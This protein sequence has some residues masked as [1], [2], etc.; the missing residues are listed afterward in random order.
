MSIDIV[1]F[2]MQ[3]T[4]ACAEFVISEAKVCVHSAPQEHISTNPCKALTQTTIGYA[5]ADMLYISCLSHC[6]GTDLSQHA[7]AKP[8]PL[9]TRQCNVRLCTCTT[10]TLLDNAHHTC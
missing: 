10:F 8:L 5:Y 4:E 1:L 7:F 6:V 2:G 3:C 9:Q